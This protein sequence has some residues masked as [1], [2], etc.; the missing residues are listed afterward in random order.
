MSIVINKDLCPQ[1]HFCP[2]VRFC[3]V[4]ALKQKDFSAPTLD[5][6]LCIDCGRCISACPSGAINKEE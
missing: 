6:S 3:P 5:E 4:S 2:A 1:N